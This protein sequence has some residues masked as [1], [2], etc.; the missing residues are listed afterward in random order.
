MRKTVTRRGFNAGLVATGTVAPFAIAKAQAKVLKIGAILPRS[1]V[2]AFFGQSCYKGIEIAAQL[3]GQI[4]YDQKIEVMSA[5]FESNVELARSRAEKLINDGA[6]VLIGPFDS[7]AAMAI[8]QVTEQRRIPFIVN[9]AAVPALTEQGYKTVFRLFPTSGD[10]VANGLAGFKSVFQATG[11]TPS[12]AVFMCIN[13]T[14]GQANKAAIEKLFP[15]MNMPFKILDT[16]TYDPAARDLSVEVAKAKATNADLLMVVSRLNDAIILVREMVKQRWEP[17]GIMSPGSPGMYEAQFFQTLGKYSDY[18][19][20]IIPWYNPNTKLAAMIGATFNQKYPGESLV[21]NIFNIG[22][23]FES[24]MVAA[25]AFKR[26]GTSDS[27]AMLEALA[28]T[29]ITNRVMIGGP[30]QFNAKGQNVNVGSAVIQNFQQRPMVV[31][32]KD[33]A[34]AQPVFPIPGWSQR[35]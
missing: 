35:G 20:T 1:G 12:T 4:G 24:M 2:Q 22:F 15:T 30:I 8:A 23:S 9:I 10:L 5:D 28:K 17:M 32:P 3:L 19:T 13:D 7:G 26:A 25:D 31:L 33:A 14:F 27:A 29:D 21:G 11:K 6:N 18:C 16:I 34:E